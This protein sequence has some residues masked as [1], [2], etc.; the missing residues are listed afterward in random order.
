MAEKE[1]RY[2]MWQLSKLAK[3]TEEGSRPRLTLKHLHAL[4]VFRDAKREEAKA[5]KNFIAKMYG[6][7]E[8]EKP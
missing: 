8:H 7:D 1:M 6:G 5:Q 2:L 3:Q 4:R